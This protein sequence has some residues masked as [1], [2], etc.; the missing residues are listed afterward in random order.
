MASREVEF[1]WTELTLAVMAGVMRQVIN[2]KLGRTD[3]YGAERE[4]PWSKHIRGACGEKAAAKFYNLYWPGVGQLRAKDVGPLQVRTTE[5]GKR[6]IL[7][8]TDDDD[9]RFVLVCG[10]GARW[11]VMG[12]CFGHEGKRTEYWSDPQHTN[13]WA[14]FVPTHILHD[15]ATVLTHVVPGERA[16]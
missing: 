4:D 10:E 5:P 7:H 1:S 16:G 6:L 11:E 13:R 12:W 3:Y 15:A 9:D 2:L 14:Y 8:K